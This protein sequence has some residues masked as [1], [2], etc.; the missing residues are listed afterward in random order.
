M[1]TNGQF[2]YFNYFFKTIKRY[3][4][5]K[6]R[7]YQLGLQNY[8]AMLISWGTSW[9]SQFNQQKLLESEQTVTNWTFI[10]FFYSNLRDSSNLYKGLNK[11][12]ALSFCVSNHIV[13]YTLKFKVV[14]FP[15]VN[16]RPI[17]LILHIYKIHC[18]KKSSFW[19]FC[20]QKLIPVFILF[21][22]FTS[23]RF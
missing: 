5:A 4:E 22:L 3:I 11:T 21:Y 17:Y 2:K 1:L 13:V 8:F 20:L 16:I 14:H 12:W 10:V 23:F 18:W 15:K 9:C 6:I 7:N 19:I